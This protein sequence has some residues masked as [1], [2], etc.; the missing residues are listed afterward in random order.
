[1]YPL[2]VMMTH[3]VLSIPRWTTLWRQPKADDLD[4]A[5]EA[6]AAFCHHGRKFG[7]VIIAQSHTTNDKLGAKEFGISK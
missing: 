4:T 7:E 1:M 6:P 2:T 5:V 3:H